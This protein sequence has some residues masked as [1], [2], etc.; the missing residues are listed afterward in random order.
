MKLVITGGS[1]FIGSNLVRKIINETHHSV[2]N[3]DNITYAGKNKSLSTIENNPKYKHYKDDIRDPVRLREIFEKEKPEA[4]LHLAAESHVDR[5]IGAPV[6]FIQTNVFGT[7]TMLETTRSYL[8]QCEHFVRSQFKFIHVS[9]DEVFGSLGLD[10]LPFTEKSRY[11]PNSPYSASKASSDFLVRSWNKTYKVP[12]LITNCS[13]NYGPRQNTEKFVPKIITNLIKN[14]VVPV[15]GNGKNIRDWLHVEDHCSALLKLLDDGKVGQSYCIGGNNE[16][17]NNKIVQIIK[18][19]MQ[20]KLKRSNLTPLI[21]Y[22][23]DRSG[24]DYRYAINSDKIKLLGWQPSISFDQGIKDTID[25]YLSNMD[26]WE[27]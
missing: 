16:I 25:W 24:H 17:S 19:E 26:W 13:N 2:V 1:G 22:V 5:S 20:E 14:K 11:K 8:S 18:E 21:S 4:V 3:I 10:D 6:I 15:Y 12:S 23:A 9:T 27:I 7:Y